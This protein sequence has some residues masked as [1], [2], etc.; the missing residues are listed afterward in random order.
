MDS[1]KRYY[2][3][4]NII[5]FSLVLITVASAFFIYQYT[6]TA[7]LSF[8][9]AENFYNQKRYS[10]AIV[11]YKKSLEQKNTIYSGQLRLAE[12]YVAIGEFANAVVWYKHYLKAHPN[13]KRA[14]LSLARALTWNLDYKEAE[15]EYKNLEKLNE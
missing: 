8:R 6:N 10:D 12:S 3:I 1:I 13:D 9:Q 7:W 2:R 4:Q 14:H 11:F 15:Q 5:Y